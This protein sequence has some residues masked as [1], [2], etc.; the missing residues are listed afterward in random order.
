MTKDFICLAYD[1][2]DEED[3]SIVYQ[4]GSKAWWSGSRLHRENGPAVIYSHGTSYW[5]RYGKIHRTDGPA[6]TRADGS[7]EWWIDGMRMS[8]ARAFQQRSKCDDEFIS[9]LL[10]TF[11]EIQ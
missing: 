5:Y 9:Y 1:H 10:L 2:D 8:S 6:V 7:M 3:D 4:D 11:G